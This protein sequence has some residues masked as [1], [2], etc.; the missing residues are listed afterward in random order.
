MLGWWW[1]HDTPGVF[2]SLYGLEVVKNF[3]WMSE[4]IHCWTHLGMMCSHFQSYYSLILINIYSYL[5]GLFL[6]IWVLQFSFR[7]FS[8]FIKVVKFIAME[9]FISFLGIF[10][11]FMRFLVL[12]W[13]YLTCVLPLP[14]L[15]LSSP[16]FLFFL[17]PLMVFVHWV[18]NLFYRPFWK[19]NCLA[20]LI[21]LNSCFQV[22]CF[23]FSLKNY[24]LFVVLSF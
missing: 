9:L 7:K 20:L 22:H 5:E 3:T 15:C 2:S 1:S 17:L 4:T 16:F 11:L 21:L 14:S 10:K 23:P 13:C 24:F 12:L 18:R 8:H 19:T 6:L